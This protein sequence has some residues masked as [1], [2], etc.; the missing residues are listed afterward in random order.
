MSPEGEDLVCGAVGG[1][2]QCCRGLMPP[3]GMVVAEVRI[4][5]SFVTNLRKKALPIPQFKSL[6]SFKR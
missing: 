6:C 1:A 2:G 3:S 4:V 5:S